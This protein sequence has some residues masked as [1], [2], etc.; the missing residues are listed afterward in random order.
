MEEA[1]V[2]LNRMKVDG[3]L[4]QLELEQSNT[5]ESIELH[6]PYDDKPEVGDKAHRISDA[7]GK[8]MS[9]GYC[10]GDGEYYC[11]SNE[12]A[13]AY[14]KRIGYGSLT[15]AYVNSEYYYT[16][17]EEGEEEYEWNGEKWIEIEG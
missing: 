4:Y 1:E 8:P 14:A 16:S 11:E 3:T 9:E 7:T 12:E 17:W 13:E 15:E 6:K 2:M 5:D 10:F